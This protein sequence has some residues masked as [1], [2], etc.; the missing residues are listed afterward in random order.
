MIFLLALLALLI[1]FHES[2]LVFSLLQSARSQKAWLPIGSGIV[3]I[4][5]ALVAIML[6]S[7]YVLA[8]GFGLYRLWVLVDIS[9]SAI[10]QQRPPS[11]LLPINAFMVVATSV[12]LGLDSFWLFLG[13]YVLF[14]LSSLIVGRRILADRLGSREA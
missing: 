12:A 3:M 9:L 6:Q 1:L 5:V 2:L 8:I 11:P 14:W 13:G 7:W 10:R 4:S